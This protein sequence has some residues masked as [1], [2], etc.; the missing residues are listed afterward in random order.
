MS[1]VI[2]CSMIVSGLVS[3]GMMRFQMR[4]ME[5]WLD[6]FFEKETEWNKETMRDFVR[7]IEKTIGGRR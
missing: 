7:S 2:L 3:F 5:K 6:R 4:M 1:K